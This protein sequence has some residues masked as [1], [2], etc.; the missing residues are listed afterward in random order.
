MENSFNEIYVSINHNLHNWN[1]SCNIMLNESCDAWDSLITE[2]FDNHYLTEGVIKKVKTT[3]GNFFKTAILACEKLITYIYNMLLKLF[4]KASFKLSLIY[5]K[6]KYKKIMEK[7]TNE[8]KS[9][10]DYYVIN[11]K[12]LLRELEYYYTDVMDMADHIFKKDYKSIDVIESDIQEYDDRFYDLTVK[13]EEAIIDLKTD[14]KISGK[15]FKKA[16]ASECYEELAQMA[17]GG[18]ECLNELNKWTSWIIDYDG[19]MNQ[20]KLKKTLMPTELVKKKTCFITK[21]ITKAST[22]I[23]NVIVKIIMA[24]VFVF[25]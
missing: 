16:T 23:K 4:G 12:K 14:P 13:L 8:T 21:I 2:M 1:R 3:T 19:K 9:K 10:K 24:I 5:A 15:Y 18:D 11:T 25:A 17:A 20:L 7:Q 22:A 6:N